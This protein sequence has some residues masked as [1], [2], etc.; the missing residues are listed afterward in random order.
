MIGVVDDVKV[1]P[2]QLDDPPARPQARAITGRFGPGDNQTHQPLPLPC[3][4][5]WWAAGRRAGA[6]PGAALAPVRAFPAA[7]GP[8]V[9]SEA[10]GHHMNRDVTLKQFDGAEAPSLEFSRAPL[11]AHAVPP[12][13]QH[14]FLGH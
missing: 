14:N 11:W 6:E 8:P 4:Q 13:E 7:Y 10:L 1:A 9:D 5:L 12:T 2:D 3:T